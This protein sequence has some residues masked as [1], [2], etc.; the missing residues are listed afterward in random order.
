MEMAL[1]PSSTK[2]RK[3]N[4]KTNNSLSVLFLSC[5]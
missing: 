1:T 5:I 3:T 2:I 4:N